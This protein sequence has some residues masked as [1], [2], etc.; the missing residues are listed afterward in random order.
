MLQTE[1]NDLVSIT[2]GLI[3][4]VENTVRGIPVI[5]SGCLLLS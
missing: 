3:D 1:Y 5:V 4:T 2:A